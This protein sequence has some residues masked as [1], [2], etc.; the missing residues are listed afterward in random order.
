MVW[1]SSTVRR[2]WYDEMELGKGHAARRA[3]PH[4]V[5]LEGS[6]RVLGNDPA[7]FGH[8]VGVDHLVHE[9]APAWAWGNTYLE[10]VILRVR[11]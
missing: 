4:V 11:R 6:V 8:C 1:D 10:S 7:Q 9:T 2:P 3:R 5:R